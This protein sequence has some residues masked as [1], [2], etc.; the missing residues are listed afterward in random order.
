[1]LYEASLNQNKGNVN[2]LNRTAFQLEHK[3]LFY[4]LRH[5]A[6]RRGYI[7]RM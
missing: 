6:K 2:I 7:Q 4:A 5:Q 1:M 3:I